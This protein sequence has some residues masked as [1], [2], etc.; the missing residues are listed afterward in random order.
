VAVGG[1]LDRAMWVVNLAVMVLD[2]LTNSQDLYPQ[3]ANLLLHALH[4]TVGLPK[5]LARIV[6][7]MFVLLPCMQQFHVLNM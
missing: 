1:C 4:L 7:H 2:W 6:N 3:A 5:F